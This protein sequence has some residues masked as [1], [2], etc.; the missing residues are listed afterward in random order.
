MKSLGPSDEELMLAYQVA[1]EGAFVELFKRYNVRI[2]N[3]FLRHLGNR[4]MAEDLLQSTF[5]KVHRQRKSYRPSAAFSTWIFTIASNLLKDASLA[6]RRRGEVVQ[7]EEVRERVAAGSSRS[8]PVLASS[9]KNP[10]AEYEEREIA[11]YIRQAVQ[12]LPP[13]QRSVI[14]LAKYEGFKYGEIAE[15]L[16][17]TVSA[18]K[19]RVHRAMKTLEQILKKRFRAL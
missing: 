7:L 17:I 1:D 10:E 14:L 12:S 11:E 8:E 5:L 4:A 6:Q 15:I 9:G 19:V 18:A 3:Y 13:D 16:N 2:F